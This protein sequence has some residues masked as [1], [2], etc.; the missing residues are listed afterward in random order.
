MRDTERKRQRHRQRE[1]QAP[2]KKP[3]TGLNPRS[4]GSHLG[5]K[6]GAK[7]LSYPGTQRFSY[8]WTDGYLSHENTGLQVRGLVFETLSWTFLLCDKLATSLG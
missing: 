1:K 7:P 4:P 6:A 2:H 5:L 3:N 8:S